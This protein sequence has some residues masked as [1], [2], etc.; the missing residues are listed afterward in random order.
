MAV[1]TIE[2][3]V[4]GA[5]LGIQPPFSTYLPHQI[6]KLPPPV[7]TSGGSLE[8]ATNYSDQIDEVFRRNV[9]TAAGMGISSVKTG[10]SIVRG[11]RSPEPLSKLRS[12]RG[13]SPLWRSTGPQR[14]AKAWTTA[15]S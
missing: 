14:S 4:S 11:K 2:Y 9:P 1:W 12:G 7:M 3:S 6:E 5:N 10:F 13:A 8:Q 15:F